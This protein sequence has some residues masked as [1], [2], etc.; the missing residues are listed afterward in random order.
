MKR[1][2]EGKQFGGWRSGN[3]EIGSKR[4]WGTDYGDRAR[5]G[6]SAEITLREEYLGPDRASNLAFH[7]PFHSPARLLARAEHCGTPRSW[8]RSGEAEGLHCVGAVAHEA[9]HKLCDLG[10][11]PKQASN[12]L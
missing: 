3:G 11:F 2:R 4:V 12:L 5:G 6:L 9:F 8:E 10:Q 7:F 1:R